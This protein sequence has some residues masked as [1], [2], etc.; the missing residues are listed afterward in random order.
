MKKSFFI[1]A[2][3]IILLTNNSMAKFN[4]VS[5]ESW[6]YKAVKY[7]SDNNILN[8]IDN[9]LFAPQSNITR[10]M[11]AQLFY[12]LENK[13]NITSG[14]LYTD[15][16]NGK[17]YEK[18]ITWAS[19]NNIVNGVGDNKFAPNENVTKEQMITMLYNY[20]T[21]K[22][23]DVSIGEDT[24][25][26]S[27]S[28]IFD[29]AE[30]AYSPMQWA[31]GAQIIVGDNGK[32]LPKK[33]LTRAEVASI[34]KNFRIY[35]IEDR[36]TA[37]VELTGNITTGYQWVPVWYED[38]MVNVSEYDYIENENT[39]V[40]GASGK[41][42]F[43]IKALNKG[44]TIVIFN[45]MRSW[46]DTPIKTVVCN[47]EIDE[48]LKLSQLY[49]EEV[50]YFITQVEAPKVVECAGM[51]LDSLETFEQY[52]IDANMNDEVFE[53][54]KNRLT[55]Y[56]SEYF[57]NSRILA[58]SEQAEDIS[59]YRASENTVYVFINK[60]SIEKDNMAYIFVELPIE[61]YEKVDNV[62]ILN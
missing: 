60:P 35:Y 7:V 49:E 48:I 54:V 41:F 34:I 20:A 3:F 58:I 14:N 37:W 36:Y 24:N 42:R 33:Q 32:L 12:N 40:V 43:E 52:K 62:V 56:S 22:K 6:Y 13:P 19:E 21:Y 4:D 55:T 50:K 18:A 39:E 59:M 47:V 5:E 45:Y 11:S 16:E 29:L 31:C 61:K 26:L 2:V 53:E 8:G 9:N 44:N 57:N 17:W 38:N 23:Y 1:I 46:E 30:Y 28:D 25:I 10:A 15:V 51:V 27:Y